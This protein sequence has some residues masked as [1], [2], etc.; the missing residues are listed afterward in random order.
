MPRRQAAASQL[1]HH[2]ELGAAAAHV[3]LLLL[4]AGRH[5]A[6]GEDAYAGLWLRLLKRQAVG[7]ELLVGGRHA[8]SSRRAGAREYEALAALAN[9]T[10]Q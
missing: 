4:L 6:A 5:G 3:G 2:P 7:W 8:C 1:L 10:G 9:P